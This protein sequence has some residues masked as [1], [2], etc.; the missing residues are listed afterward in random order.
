[1]GFAQLAN[2]ATTETGQKELVEYLGQEEAQR[3]TSF[4]IQ[5]YLA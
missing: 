2:M 1:M 5:E 4:W 3:I